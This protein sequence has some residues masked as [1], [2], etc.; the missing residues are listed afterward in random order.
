MRLY[1]GPIK[2]EGGQHLP[3][4]GPYVLAIKHFSRWDPMV[5]S[6]ISRQPFRYMTND[7]QFSGVQGWFLRHLGAYPVSLSQPQ[8][9]SLKHTIELLH[10]GQRVA[11]F[12]EG[13]IVRDQ[14]LRT[15]KPGLARLIMTAER[16][17]PSPKPI[18]IIPVALHYWPAAQRGAMITV[19]ICPALTSQSAQAGTEKEQSHQLTRHLESVLRAAL[20]SLRHH[21]P[22]AF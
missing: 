7:N 18:P 20:E 4:D 21:S 19:K 1:F 15:L 10:Q 17:A 12:P 13:G 22:Q 14:V 11:I 9:S 16:S 6:L 5:V 3:L 8:R 2:I